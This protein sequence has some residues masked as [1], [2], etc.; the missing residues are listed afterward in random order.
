MQAGVVHAFAFLDLGSA[1][2]GIGVYL[3]E[4]YQLA[5]NFFYALFDMLS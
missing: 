1:G 3:W 2:G 5:I 4:Q